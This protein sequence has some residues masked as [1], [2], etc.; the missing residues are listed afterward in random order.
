MDAYS[1]AHTTELKSSQTNTQYYCCCSLQV[2]SYAGTFIK[3][4]V[5][6]LF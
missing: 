5:G 3:I 4:N 1:F 2:Y 6:P